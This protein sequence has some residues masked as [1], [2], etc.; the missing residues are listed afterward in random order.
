MRQGC[1][2]VVDE[3]IETKLLD[4]EQSC[5]VQYNTPFP[6]PSPLTST[7]N[8]SHILVREEKKSERSPLESIL[9]HDLSSSEDAQKTGR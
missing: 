4:V 6:S 2:C 3:W 7:L 1:R 9:E 8:Q 5:Q